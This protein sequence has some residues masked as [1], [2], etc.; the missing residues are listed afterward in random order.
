MSIRS[1]GA[2]LIFMHI[3]GDEAKLQVIATAQNYSGNFDILHD[4]LRRGDIIGVTGNPGR[5]KTNEL[6]IRASK[7][8][9][10]S[11]CYH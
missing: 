2:K 9:L 7:I 1:S 4:A 8:E 6:S 10:L 5:T 11:Y 3:H